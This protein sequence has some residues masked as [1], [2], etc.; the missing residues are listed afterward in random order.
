MFKKS[1]FIQNA[2]NLSQ[3]FG[4]AAVIGAV[5]MVGLN[6][7]SPDVTSKTNTT[8]AFSLMSFLS[9]SLITGFYHHGYHRGQWESLAELMNLAIRCK[10]YENQIEALQLQLAIYHATNPGVIHYP[11]PESS[12]TSSDNDY[13]ILSDYLNHEDGSEESRHMKFR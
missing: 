4:S 5:C 1:W 6:M 11:S 9:V 7:T 10:K 12:S 3:I 13:D 8:I 2:Q